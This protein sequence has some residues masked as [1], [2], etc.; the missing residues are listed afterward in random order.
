MS[1]FY[2]RHFYSR[3]YKTRNTG[4]RTECGKRGECPLGFRGTCQRFP[5]NVIILTFRGML[6]KILRNAPKDSGE[7]SRRFRGMLKKVPG[8]LVKILWN[9]QEDS[10]E[11]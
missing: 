5:V 11:Y 7:C 8:M 9:A 10:G 6:K 3:L 4:M 2:K 1:F